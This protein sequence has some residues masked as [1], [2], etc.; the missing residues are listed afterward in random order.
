MDAN[1]VGAVA[2]LTGVSVRTLHHYDHIGLVVPSVRTSAGYRGYTDA[3]I[4]RL[5]VV[6]V[7]RSVGLPLEEIRALLDGEAN[8][9]DHLERQHRLLLEQADRLQHTIK[10][11]E[12]LMSAH[13]SGIQLTAEEQVEIFGPEAHTRISTEYA[14]EA[15]ER[16]G[17]TDAWKQSQQRASRFTKQDWID[18][19]A[20]GDAL[21]QALAEAKRRGVVA[22]S[23][24]ADA[25]AERHRLS[26]ERFYDC[27]HE[28]QV[29]LAQMYVAD[30]R[31]T[32]YYD[33]V[34]PGLAQFLHDI[35]VARSDR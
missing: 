17:D 1:T 24:E 14:A 35:I 18:I 32:R 33:D 21:L 27:D 12:E 13:R 5:H 15:E 10:A 2:A 26:I 23:A 3:D 31:F 7:Y 34:E 11:V 4:E 30:E 29:C 6:L 28:M 20:E 25:L 16:W 19:K 8:V 9:L 22:G